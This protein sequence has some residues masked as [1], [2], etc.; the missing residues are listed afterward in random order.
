M[1]STSQKWLIGCGTG[2]A[3]VVIVIVFLVGGAVVYIRDKIRPL[4]EASDSRKEIVAAYGD[5]ESYVPPPDGEIRAERMEIFLS[6]R[7]SMKEAQSRLDETLANVDF[8]RLTQ[9]NQSFGEALRTLTNVGNLIGPVGEYVGRRNRALLDRRMGLGEYAY[10]YSIAY[11]SWLGHLPEEGP[12]AL[13]GFFRRNRDRHAGNAGSFT[14]EAVRWQYRRFISRMLEN[15]LDGIRDPGRQNRRDAI[16]REIERIDRSLVRVAW[17]DNLPSP[18][19]E[20][21]KPY[22]SRLESTY[23]Q[24]TNFFELLTLDESRRFEWSGPGAE[25]ETGTERGSEPIPAEAPPEKVAP[26]AS[27]KGAPAEDLSADRRVSYTVGSGVTAPTVILQPM[28]AYTDEA[29]KASAEGVV[30]VQAIIRK[31]GSIGSAKV[32]RRLG[33]GL[34]ESAVRTILKDWKFKPGTL[35]GKPVD[36]PVNIEVVFRPH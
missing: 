8:E 9:R 36:V 26:D 16:R 5:A 12:P 21:L 30:A 18:V 14:P 17:Q 34:D 1:D 3:V 27:R 13:A 6:V 4:Q 11:H 25:V 24:S 10:V 31:D 23:H 20:S 28:P 22:R 33:Y 2:C 19:E 29:R 7:D 32:V 15:Q 35:N